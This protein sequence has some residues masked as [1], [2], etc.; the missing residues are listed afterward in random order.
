MNASTAHRASVS[1]D[2]GLRRKAV[3]EVPSDPPSRPEPRRVGGTWDSAAF[4]RRSPAGRVIA[5]HYVRQ[6]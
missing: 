6:V 4:L 2:G 3:S 5:D 1:G